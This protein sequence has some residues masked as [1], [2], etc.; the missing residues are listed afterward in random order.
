MDG[1]LGRRQTEDQPAMPDVDSGEV[2][3]VAKECAVLV[4]LLAVE[5]KVGAGDHQRSLAE[6]AIRQPGILV[7]MSMP[8]SPRLSKRRFAGRSSSGLRRNAGFVGGL[9]LAALAIGATGY[10]LFA[11]LPWLDA[12]LNAAMILTGMG[13]VNPVTTPA[14]KMFAIVYALFS[15]VFF[16]TMVAVLLAPGVQHLLHRFHL[17]LDEEQA[18]HPGRAGPADVHHRSDR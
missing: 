15:G 7:G 11:G 10:H 1:Q 8:K 6:I 13:P 4:R 9:I 2:E 16:L 12:A 14:A 17:E 3:H 18:A 5:Q